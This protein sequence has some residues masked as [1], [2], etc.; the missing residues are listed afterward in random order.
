MIAERR[1]FEKQEND[2]RTY[3]L[4]KSGNTDKTLGDILSQYKQ[5]SEK[6][7]GR[8]EWSDCAAALLI[9]RQEP[10]YVLTISKS[11]TEKDIYG[12]NFFLCLTSGSE[13]RNKQVINNLQ[14]RTGIELIDRPKALGPRL[15]HS[16]EELFLQLRQLTDIF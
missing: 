9:D 11:D 12:H 14:E 15:T 13:E 10:V 5:G 16:N 7:V 3:T 1:F 8:K 6:V 2:G 4:S